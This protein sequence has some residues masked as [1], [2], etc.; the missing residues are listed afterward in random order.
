M[1]NPAVSIT[2][3][4]T[5]RAAG[6]ERPDP[7]GAALS[8]ATAAKVAETNAAGSIQ[9]TAIACLSAC[10]RACSATVSGDG[11]FSYVIGGLTPDDAG[12]LVAFAEA[13]AASADGIPP[14]RARPERIRKNT[15]A[16]LPPHGTPHPLIERPSAEATPEEAS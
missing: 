2:I 4:R 3:C 5:C 13:H 11:K 7:P 16:R 8:R 14:W 12:D 9:V 6:D 1:N 10:S 15:I